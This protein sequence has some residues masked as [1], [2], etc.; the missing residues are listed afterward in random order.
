MHCSP[1]TAL[2]LEDLIAGDGRNV[3]SV[4]EGAG[5]LVDGLGAEV[6]ST[7]D[8]VGD[9]AGD[10]GD[11]LGGRRL[12]GE[13]QHAIGIYLH[14]QGI[15]QQPRGCW[16]VR[17]SV[18]SIRITWAEDIHLQLTCLSS[19]SCLQAHESNVEMCIA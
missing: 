19:S 8:T 7:E 6:E 12:L 9:V 10:I 4:G 5:K 15:Q 16:S 3:L 11:D 18:L 1:S 14:L 2:L 17:S 13:S